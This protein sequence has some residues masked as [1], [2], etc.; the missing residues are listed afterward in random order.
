MSICRSTMRRPLLVALLALAAHSSFAHNPYEL[1]ATACLWSNR[2]D[3]DVVMEFRTGLRLAGVAPQAPPGVSATNWFAENQVGLLTCAKSFCEI[4]AGENSLP[5]QSA[6]VALGVED[7]VEF[8][9]QYPPAT[10]HP[11]RFEAAGLKSLAGQGQYGVA[12]TVLDM[13][14][15]RVLGQ[16]VVF[17]DAPT[18]AV[19][20]SAPAKTEIIAPSPAAAVKATTVGTNPAIA[21]DSTTPPAKPVSNPVERGL[22]SGVAALLLLAVVWRCSRRRS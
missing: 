5:V 14:H 8:H 15:G 9:I 12:L 17:A 6:V 11:L 10:N 18:L 13:V 7:H 16:P 19:E 2:V 21:L 3:L 4:Q 1:S 22:I 20:I